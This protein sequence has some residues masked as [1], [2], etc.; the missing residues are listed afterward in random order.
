[1]TPCIE[2]QTTTFKDFFA[3]SADHLLFFKCKKPQL[4][5][6]GKSEIH[7]GSC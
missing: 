1:M 7:K 5:Q 4:D 3:F 6:Y 2:V